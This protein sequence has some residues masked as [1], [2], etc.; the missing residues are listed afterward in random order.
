M[1]NGKNYHKH[2]DSKPQTQLA[3]EKFAD[4]MIARMEEMKE[5]HWK[6]GWIDGTGGYGLPQNI[7]SGTLNGGN[8]FFLQLDTA[9]NGYKMPLYMTFLQAQNMGLRI[10]KGAESMPVI[11]WDML[12]KDQNGKKVDRSDIDMMTKEERNA[13]TSTPILRVY[14]EFNVDQT[15]LAEVNPEKYAKLQ[16]RFKAPELR[17]DKG[18]YVNAAI[19]RMLQRQE[20]LCPVQYDQMASGASFS[21]SKDRIVIPMKSQFNISSTP[22]EIYK[23]GMEYYSTFLHEATHS[24]GT[25]ERLNRVK[26]KQ[27]GDT[28]YGH[29]EYVAEMT[30][31]VV[32]NSENPKIILSIL[33]DVNKA[34]NMLLE[35]IDEQ[36]I[37]LGETPVLDRKGTKLEPAGANFENAAI[38]KQKNGE[39]AARASLNGT[40]LEMKPVAREIGIRYFS[41]PEG[42]EKERLLTTT[43]NSSYAADISK[44]TQ[45]QT[46]GYKVG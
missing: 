39:F 37:A 24:T 19:D 2:S 40:E 10:N 31:A 14:K 44:L 13:L 26:G 34:S 29:E 11:F 25:P 28:Q 9:M 8:S 42:K 22:E 43:L 15:N 3:I 27:F 45:H 7:A 4:M 21:P 38:V 16:E 12:Y 41:L 1:Q 36:K 23:D 32:G 5:S 18:M 35:K 20:W 6:K 30:A 33:S 17:D 46:R